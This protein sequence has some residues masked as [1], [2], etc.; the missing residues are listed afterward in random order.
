MEIPEEDTTRADAGCK[1]KLGLEGR[2]GAVHKRSSVI[3]M[4]RYQTV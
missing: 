3:T 2:S 1:E 4:A